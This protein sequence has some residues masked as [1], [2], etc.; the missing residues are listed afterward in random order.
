MTVDSCFSPALFPYYE[1]KDAHRIIVIVDIF[2]AS[3][4]L[5]AAFAAG[6]KS[7]RTVA[8]VEEARL[9]KQNGFLVGAERNTERCDFA[10]FGNSPKEYSSDKI[11]GK[12][13]VFTTTN[14]TQAL[15][16]AL[17]ESGSEIIIGAFVNLSSVAEYCSTRNKDVLVL[18][19][20][21]NNRVN[22]EDALFA[23][24]LIENMEKEKYSISSD[25]AR[26]AYDM[27]KASK[28]DLRSYLNRSEHI[29]R[30]F[31]HGLDSDIDFCLNIDTVNVLPIYD[32][33]QES[34]RL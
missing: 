19:A 4:T 30:L 34:L 24:A 29:S 28:T 21:W 3:T 33:L 27:W 8:S 23:G 32:R 26:I 22:I 16:M 14:G 7:I 6:V 2:R 20:G 1:L 17:S 9:A 10:D 11:K 12:E 15:D 5:C 18:C 13:L 31:R 25:A